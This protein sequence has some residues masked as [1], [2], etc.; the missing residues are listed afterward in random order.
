VNVY[1]RVRKC[2]SESER[3]CPPSPI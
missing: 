1:V 3:V 2:V